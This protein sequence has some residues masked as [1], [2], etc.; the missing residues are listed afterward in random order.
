M[1]RKNSNSNSN[2]NTSCYI[3]HAWSFLGGSE[4]RARRVNIASY[5]VP[6]CIRLKKQSS[7]IIITSDECCKQAFCWRITNWQRICCFLSE[8]ESLKVLGQFGCISEA[9]MKSWANENPVSKLDSVWDFSPEWM[10]NE[11]QL[12]RNK[13]DEFHSTRAPKWWSIFR[14]QT[15]LCGKINRNAFHFRGKFSVR[16]PKTR[17]T[18]SS[19]SNCR[20]LFQ[21]DVIFSKWTS[22]QTPQ[23]ANKYEILHSFT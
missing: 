20:H 4:Q 5:K 15:E 23:I 11:R 17:K 14:A 9:P 10:M 6:F 2:T 1:T 8:N 22:K 18:P 7:L 12:H 21:L 19:S 3:G 13:I 16:Y